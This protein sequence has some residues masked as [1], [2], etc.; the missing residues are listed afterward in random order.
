V[1]ENGR[2]TALSG[3]VAVLFGSQ[4]F[5]AVLGVFNGIL[6]A[7]LLGPAGKGDYYLLILMPATVMVLLQLGL[8]QAFGYFGARGQTAGIL[9]KVLLLTVGLS[10]IAYLVVAVV[11]PV[12]REAALETLAP[13]HIVL[14]F[15]A[16]P[17][18]F[19]STLT[20]AIVLARHA[21]RW[22]VAVEIVFSVATTVLLLLVLGGFQASLGAAVG[23]Y[24][25][26][27]AIQAVGLAFGARHATADVPDA[28]PVSYRELFGY[29][30]RYFP[31]SLAGFFSYRIDAY[32]IAFLIAASS[33][34]LGYYSMAV[35]LAEMV[36]FIPRA[37]TSVFF[38]HVAGSS[39][40]DSDRHL[41]PITR[42]TVL[43]TLAAGLLLVPA[44]AIMLRFLLPDFL[45]ALTPL[46]VLLP[47][48]VVLSAAWSSSGY[49]TGIGRPGLTSTIS[50]V[51][52]AVNVA[53]NLLLIPQLGIVGAALAS[54]VSYTLSAIVLT[55]VAARFSGNR[56]DTLWVPRSSDVRFL[57]ETTADLIRRLLGTTRAAADQRRA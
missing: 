55:A 54:L 7:R 40:E 5:G 30:L 43:V 21:V 33:E 57:F 45:P 35:G 11:V 22:F 24:L 50:L 4:V 10:A 3:N 28:R 32:L 52:L 13:E 46:L 41:A 8:P 51:S 29:G 1:S 9:R 34:Q 25:A 38:P 6:L 53:V 20:T 44:A 12:L 18:A 42:M 56:L 36:F 37:V 48:V 23:V 15:L 26:T 17:L 31:G 19:S 2:A 27:V 16:V 49:L 14:A 39:R 47:G